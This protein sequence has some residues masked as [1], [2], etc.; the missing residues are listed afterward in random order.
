MDQ[1]EAGPIVDQVSICYLQLWL[2]SR[3]RK[4]AC[5]ADQVIRK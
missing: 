3:C 5:F 1:I 2:G 4:E